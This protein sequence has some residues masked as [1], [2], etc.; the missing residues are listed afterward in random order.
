MGRVS[1]R[2]SLPRVRAIDIDIR[3]WSGILFD[4]R[5]VCL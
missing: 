1:I 3:E 5:Y 2:R 4:C